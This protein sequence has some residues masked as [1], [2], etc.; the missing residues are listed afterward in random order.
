MSKS[1]DKRLAAQVKSAIDEAINHPRGQ[2]PAGCDVVPIER[3]ALRHI[4]A[5]VERLRRENLTLAHTS[6]EADRAIAK[7]RRE[8]RIEGF[9]LANNRWA[10]SEGYVLRTHDDCAVEVDDE[11]PEDAPKE[12]K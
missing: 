12:D 4:Y 10:D 3:R 6:A 9:Q 2:Q 5:E 1:M 11:W 7:A 8:G